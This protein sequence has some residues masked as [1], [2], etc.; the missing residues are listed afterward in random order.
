MTKKRGENITYE[1][2]VDRA[3]EKGVF[4]AREMLSTL[5]H[6]LGHDEHRWQFWKKREQPDFR[7][8]V[9]SIEGRIRFLFTI[10]RP[11]AS[12]LTS[13]LYAHYSDVEIVEIPHPIPEDTRLRARKVKI[14]HLN[15]ETIKLYVNLKD[16]TEKDMIDPLSSMT[17]ALTKVPRDAVGGFMIEFRP[18]E[19]SY[20]RTPAKRVILKYHLPQKLK[21]LLLSYGWMF[22]TLFFPFRLVLSFIGLLFPTEPSDSHEKKE[23]EE[24]MS[25][26]ESFGYL[27]D[28][29]LI[30]SASESLSDEYLL[31][32]IA[33][34]LN[35]F[36]NPQGNTLKVQKS[37][38]KRYGEVHGHLSKHSCL[39]NA[40][41]L[42]G[43]VHLPTLYVKTPG[44]QWVTTRKYEPPHELPS[45]E[46]PNTPI[47]RAN[48][49]GEDRDFGIQPVDRARHIY[50][51]GK[52]GMGKSTLLENM[53][54]TD[55]LNGRG[56][57][58]IDP[59]GDL[60]ET[61]LRNIPKSRT[62]D[63]ILFDPADQDFP[64]GFNMLENT[65]P[66]LRP[67]VAGGL[68]SIFKK[69]FAESW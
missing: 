35:I 34:S 12:F 49:R 62:N 30:K 45:T 64:I 5:H 47:G 53:I 68:V 15:L 22:R 16:R 7:F 25:K 28:I 27:T 59:H 54:Y 40:T 66:Q 63:I 10:P 38:V 4:V 58:V 31:K 9:L 14:A 50:V 3:N 17:S 44:I 65:N 57:G 41:E 8:E 60:V 24:E 55:I 42:A 69:M 36:A 18:V 32:E 33:G 2:S 48:Y 23:E 6:T 46:S 1:I 39:W 21:V 26:T 20:W 11:F 43:I 52:T 51:I 67:I 56:V 19:D 37:K 61:I 29:T 13:Q